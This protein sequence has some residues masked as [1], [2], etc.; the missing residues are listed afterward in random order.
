MSPEPVA[1]GREG[2]DLRALAGCALLVPALWLLLGWRPD[3]LVSGYDAVDALVPVV[4]AL[5]EA[6][7]E[8]GALAYRADLLGGTAVR[9]TLGPQPLLVC[10]AAAGLSVTWVL[11]LT[12]FAVQALLGFFGQRTL[13]ELTSAYAGTPWPAA[14]RVPLATLF[15]AFAPFVGWRVGYGH[16]TLLVGLLP[17]V[18]GFALLLASSNG[19]AGLTLTL[20]S[21][22]TMAGSLPFVGQQII[23]YGVVF[24]LPLAVGA[25]RAAGGKGRDLVLLLLVVATSLMLAAPGFAPMVAHAFGGDALRQV[26]RTSVTY[27][28]LTAQPI[29][30]LSSLP[31]GRFL[32]PGR[33]EIQYHESN[34]PLGPLLLLLV[35]VPRQGRP[36]LVGLAASLLLAMAF[37]SNLRPLSDLL[38]LALPPLRS[39][40]VPTRA[41]MPVLAVL[42]V[43]GLAALA[44]ARPAFGRWRALEVVGGLVAAAL[45]W[46]S[47]PL[48][49][50]VVAWA[51]V[52]VLVRPWAPFGAAPPTMA[53]LL[54]LGSGSLGAFR[55]R[56]LLFPDTEGLLAEARSWGAAARVAEP[57]V[58]LPLTR[59]LVVTEGVAFGA[60]RTLAAGLSG[61]DGY[62]FPQRRFVALVRALREEPYAPNA[63]LLRFHETHLA[64]RV[65][66]QL[67]NVA[68]KVD[69]GEG[70]HPLR[71]RPRGPTA[72]P[73]WFP[74][75]TAIDADWSALAR[76]LLD[77]GNTAHERA[78]AELRLL[79]GDAGEA[80]LGMSLPTLCTAAFV[81]SLRVEGAVLHVEVATPANCPLVLAMNYGGILEAWG[82]SG[83]ATARLP[84]FPAYGALLGVVVPAG[85]TEVT[86]TPAPW[87]PPWTLWTAA[88]GLL[89]AGL[90][91]R[92][93]P[94]PME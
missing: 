58:A 93:R 41:L 37:A 44:A 18:A 42:P 10:L 67:Y 19:T 1:S 17:F 7:G 74:T 80:G 33:P 70:A 5:V 32:P 86:I 69:D 75:A 54:A 62:G 78:R 91:L 4:R 3:R 34:V 21:V 8:V 29:D 47:P 65:L 27:S 77:W 43:I 88:G 55:D 30:W 48:V 24:G 12:T 83:T 89:M 63:L 23:L 85:T 92:G 45:L 84:T 64:S 46:V 14:M 13:R 82:A 49:R 57:R 15:V 26:G 39:F 90:V 53:L 20:V 11:N 16:L 28:Y 52:V 22:L 94:P 76:S 81:H 36:L 61:L 71:V 6:G 40:R 68:F 51:L 56:L 73:A 87:P 60:N 72:G 9:D 50:E 38:L 2:E 31:W 59:V 66:F 35:L 79:D 25:W